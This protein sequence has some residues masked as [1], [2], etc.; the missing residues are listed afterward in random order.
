MEN[1]TFS[2]LLQALVSFHLKGG[3]V[4]TYILTLI[5]S[6]ETEIPWLHWTAWPYQHDALRTFLFLPHKVYYVHTNP[7]PAS[8]AHNSRKIIM[9]VNRRQ[10]NNEHEQDTIS[11]ISFNLSSFSG[12]P[13]VDR[14]YG[15]Y[16]EAWLFLKFGLGRG[17]VKSIYFEEMTRGSI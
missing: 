11:I 2:I 15:G 4:N 16:W 12:I 3:E 5:K 10:G 9:A 6:N 1:S 7:T 17:F 8:L 13:G 14:I